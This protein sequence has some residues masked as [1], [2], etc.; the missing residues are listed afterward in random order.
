[1]MICA[2]SNTVAIDQSDVKSG[3]KGAEHLVVT[4]KRGRRIFTEQ[5]R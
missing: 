1:M 3:V 4:P 5:G 2:D